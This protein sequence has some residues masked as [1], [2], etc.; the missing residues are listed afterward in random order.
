MHCCAE[1]HYCCYH[2]QLIRE[3]LEPAVLLYELVTH[4][5]YIVISH[6]PE[7]WAGEERVERGKGDLCHCL[8]KYQ[9]RGMGRDH[10]MGDM[11]IPTCGHRPSCH[12][13]LLTSFM[14]S[15]KL[16]MMSPIRQERARGPSSRS[17]NSSGLN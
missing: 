8:L 2:W 16:T 13:P 4:R 3:V 14:G 6:E 10:I 7:G 11:G 1:L 9:P 12:L 17:L 15:V 5:L